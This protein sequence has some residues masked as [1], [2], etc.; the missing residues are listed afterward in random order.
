[1]TETVTLPM[2]VFLALL[3]AAG[4]ALLQHFLIPSVRYVLR[5]RV[6]RV[7]DEVNTRLNI[8]IRPFQLTKRQVLIDR[9]VFDP[10]VIE[11]I[12]AQAHETQKPREVLQAEVRRYA[13]EIV[14]AFNAYVYFRVG[15]WLANRFARLLYRVRVGFSDESRLSGIDPKATVV[16]VMNHRSNMDYVL[17]AL[18]A[19][20]HTALSYAVGE[21]ARVWP[22]QQLVRAMGAFFVR[23]NSNNPLYRR[24]LERYVYMATQEGVPQ[25]VFLEGGLSKDGK[26]RTPKLGMLDY[27]LRGYDCEHSRD[28]VFV[29]V[30]VNYDRVLEDRTLVRALDPEARRRSRWFVIRTTAGFVSHNLWLMLRNRWFRFG[31]AAV[32]FGQPI[33]MRDYCRGRNQNYAQVPQA[34]RF[35][36]IEQLAIHL[37]GAIER[38]IPVVPTPLIAASLLA[39]GGQGADE[40]TLKASFYQRV[41]ALRNSG[42]M[43]VVPTRTLE[44]T[45]E[46]ALDMLQRRRIVIEKN[47]RY[48]VSDD[49][50]DVLAYYANSIQ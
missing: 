17:V 38:Q 1:M 23:R 46:T 27:M 9:L 21:W 30:G 20:E 26:L 32:C 14:P 45:F 36:E 31:Y 19:S 49:S 13:R 39:A 4:T 2:W 18:L 28:I 48:R 42:K 24:V 3:V 44:H 10:R 37:M 33:G 47:G 41:E 22:L 11:T 43:V 29:P 12:E 16:F 6:N 34:V 5:G 25:A 35:A 15:Y 40:L 8:S 50:R 7:I